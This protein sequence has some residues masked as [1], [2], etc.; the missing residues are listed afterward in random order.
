MVQMAKPWKHENGGYYIYR[1]IP[2]PLRPAFAGKQFWKKSLRTRDAEEAKQR[3]QKENAALEERF[4][5]TRSGIASAALTNVISK[6]D[7]RLL[8]SAAL[9]SS[10]SK[11]YQAL[12][13]VWWAEECVLIAFGYGGPLHVPDDAEIRELSTSA[14]T[15]IRL[16]GDAWLEASRRE[17]ASDLASAAEIVIDGLLR[18]SLRPC[19]RSAATDKAILEAYTESVAAE[20]DALRAEVA[21]PGRRPTNRRRPDMTLLQLLDAWAVGKLPRKQALSEATDYVADLVAFVGPIP[22]AALTKDQ[23]CDYR[24]AAASLPA[25]MTK[26]DR[27]LPFPQRVAR[28]AGTE[29]AR[30]DAATV[31]KRL[32]LTHSRFHLAWRC[33]ELGAGVASR[34]CTAGAR[35]PRR[36]H[37]PCVAKG[38]QR[39]PAAS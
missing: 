6:T 34:S 1:Q 21:S 8:V 20:N 9:R 36:A 29:G 3:F 39:R 27:A 16:P 38:N 19:I 24:D 25:A 31:K 35:A 17:Q 2:E 22:A 7:A 12:R 18:D 32:G 14:A 15:D 26:R 4:A 30:V 23:L 10:G 11:P 13:R 37:Q 33:S 28:L 5:A